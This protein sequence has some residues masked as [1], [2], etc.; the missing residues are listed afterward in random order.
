MSLGPNDGYVFHSAAL[1]AFLVR[2][3]GKQDDH[4]NV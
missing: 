4:G 1:V 3:S 2:A